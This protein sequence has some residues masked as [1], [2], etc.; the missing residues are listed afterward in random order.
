MAVAAKEIEKVSETRPTTRENIKKI[1]PDVDIIEY[2]S[3][4]VLYADMPNA[5]E[6]TIDITLEKNLINIRA[7]TGSFEVPGTFRLSHSEYPL[8]RVYERRFTISDEID[9]EN[10]KASFHHGV[11]KVVLPKSEKAKA[12]KIEVISES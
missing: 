7:E 1:I 12:K 8:N 6:K 4:F 10:I 3:E 9:S 5:D 2:P 11:L